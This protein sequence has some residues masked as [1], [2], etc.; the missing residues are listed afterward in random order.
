[1]IKGNDNSDQ[2]WFDWL[3]EKS[4]KFISVVVNAA[5]NHADDDN[6]YNDYFGTFV[7]YEFPDDN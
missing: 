7:D 4:E 3:G 5:V 2:S 6:E 1:M